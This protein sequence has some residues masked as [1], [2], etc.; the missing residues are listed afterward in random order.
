[1]LENY[2]YTIDKLSKQLYIIRKKHGRTSNSP[3]ANVKMHV[4]TPPNL[5][6]Y[7]IVEHKQMKAI[8][9]KYCVKVGYLA[10][11]NNVQEYKVYTTII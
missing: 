8:D 9:V 6:M 11:K 4:R 3:F 2:N 10:S 5:D 7:L 1:M